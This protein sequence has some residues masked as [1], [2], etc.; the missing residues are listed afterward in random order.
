MNR[1]VLFLI[2]FG[3]LVLTTACAQGQLDTLIEDGTHQIIEQAAA[4]GIQLQQEGVGP[5]EITPPPPG[6][7]PSQ[8][9]SRGGD[10]GNIS[11]RGERTSGAGA[12]GE[13][14]MVDSSAPQGLALE[15]EIQPAVSWLVYQDQDFPFSIAYPDRYTILP[16][17]SQS[18]ENPSLIHQVRFLDHQL[19]AGDTADLELPNFTI[20]IYALGDLSLETFLEQ[21]SRFGNR[22]PFKLGGRDGMRVFS[23][24]LIAPNEFYYFPDR[25]YVYKLTPMGEFSQQML[26]S[27]Q[28]E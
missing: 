5:L 10:G 22:E 21:N 14:G 4:E 24:R 13:P 19:A 12:D 3:I 2:V 15:G 7:G 8:A 9:P 16:P 28:I 18:T 27:F 6:E 1:K 26:E 17:Q 23:N 20:E 25:N 11:S